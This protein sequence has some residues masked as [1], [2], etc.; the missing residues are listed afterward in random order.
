M[1]EER[2]GIRLSRVGSVRA[3]RHLD[4]TIVRLHGELDVSGEDRLREVLDD[5]VDGETATLVM[6]LRGLTFI[7]STG[8]RLLVSLQNL[9]VEHCFDYAILCG[10]GAVRRVLRET[11]LDGLLPVIDPAGA[12][13]ASDSPV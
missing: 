13:P 4:T 8:L 3:E 12:V 6:D 10:E 11:G 2:P 5:V 9:S 1:L 7:D